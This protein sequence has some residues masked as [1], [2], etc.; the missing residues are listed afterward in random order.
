MDTVITYSF[1]YI[2]VQTLSKLLRRVQNDV[3]E[4]TI[5][6]TMRIEDA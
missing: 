3:T 2:Y 4:Y 1:K 6:G 5:S